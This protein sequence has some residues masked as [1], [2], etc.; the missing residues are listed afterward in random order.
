VTVDVQPRKVDMKVKP[1]TIGLSSNDRDSDSDS[2]D[3]DRYSDEHGRLVTVHLFSN[4]TFD[5]TAIDPASVRLTNGSGK[6][7]P[8]ATR[9][10]RRGDAWEMKVSHLNYDRLRDVKLRFSREALI[11]NGDLTGSTVSLNLVSRAGTCAYVAATGSVI[12][13]Q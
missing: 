12:V 6:G 9:K 13:S 8:L 10:S 2:D 5:A 11:A 3:D 1:S 7:T 4:A